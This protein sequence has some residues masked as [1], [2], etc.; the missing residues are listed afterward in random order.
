MYEWAIEIYTQIIE[1]ALPIAIV[2]AFG[3]L[4]VGSFMR[5]AFGG[6]LWFGK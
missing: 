2:F 6:K 5:V 4:I 1:L 3:N